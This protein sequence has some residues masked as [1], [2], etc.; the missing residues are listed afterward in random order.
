MYNI[1]LFQTEVQIDIPS[2]RYQNC[3][4]FNKSGKTLA[5]A[6][7]GGSVYLWNE[8]CATGRWECAAELANI[9]MTTVTTISY[10]PSSQ[11]LCTG[12]SLLKIFKIFIISLQIYFNLSNLI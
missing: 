4:V 8:N 2:G 6:G 11:Y 1:H 5:T 12:Q 3:W 7:G 10:D 9:T